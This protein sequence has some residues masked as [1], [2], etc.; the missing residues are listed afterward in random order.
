VEARPR[1]TVEWVVGLGLLAL[2]LTVPALRDV[3]DRL[4]TL[5][6]I[7]LAAVAFVRG[8]PEWVRPFLLS[9][10][11]ALAGAVLV[12]LAVVAVS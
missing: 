7:V 12:V 11:A 10:A 9:V 5:S 1:R 3:G 4:A 8:K 6:L 2:F